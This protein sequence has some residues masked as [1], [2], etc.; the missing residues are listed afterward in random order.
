MLHDERA[1]RASVA[2]ER[3][4][5]SHA[6]R[7]ARSFRLNRL[8]HIALDSRVVSFLAIVVLWQLIAEVSGIDPVVL[9]APSQ[10]AVGWWQIS[11]N[12]QLWRGLGQTGESLAIGFGAAAVLGIVLG[13]VMG[14]VRSIRYVGDPWITILLGTPFVAFVPV[15]II[16]TGIGMEMRVLASFLFSFPLVVVNVQA[17]S[18]DVNISLVE[19]ARSYEATRL[20]TFT[21]VILP[22]AL[23]SI[24][25]GMRQGLAHA[26][27]GVVI[28]EMLT[29][30]TEGLG[31]LVNT[32]GAAFRTNILLGVIFTGLM[33]VLLANAVFDLIYRKLV[34][35]EEPSDGQTGQLATF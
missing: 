10:V 8:R 15:L 32:Y 9:P 6:E 7:E 16:W 17:G 12:G 29:T 13:V 31:G 34:R 27:K 2:T 24:L 30:A 1:D 28:A 11:S 22:G 5:L 3:P 14:L 20:Q 21:K 4:T 26:I 25:V 33:V 23:P 19:M 18:R 35:W